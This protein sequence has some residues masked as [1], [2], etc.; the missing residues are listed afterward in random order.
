MSS[1]YAATVFV[2]LLAAPHPGKPGVRVRARNSF[3]VK[4]GRR[5]C[6]IFRA[7]PYPLAPVPL[8]ESGTRRVPAPSRLAQRDVAK[9]HVS[10]RRA[11]RGLLAHS[12]NPGYLAWLTGRFVGYL[13]A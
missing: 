4:Q 2:D 1:P 13:T 9:T 12:R 8:G 6:G 10:S 3:F 7:S 11:T 5:V